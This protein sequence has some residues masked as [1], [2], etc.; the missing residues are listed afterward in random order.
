MRPP[1]EKESRAVST[2]AQPEEEVVEKLYAP[3]EFLR[4]LTPLVNNYLHLKEALVDEKV[5]DAAKGAANLRKQ[6]D[7]VKAS[8]LDEKAA[9]T[10]LKLS[11]II[12]EKAQTLSQMKEIA[13]Q[14]TAFD[15]LSEAFVRLLM[16]FRHVMKEPLSV[17]HC[18]MASEGQGTYWVESGEERR[19]PYFGSKPV[20]GQDMLH[21]G[22]LIDRIPPENAPEG[23]KSASEAVRRGQ[24]LS[25][26]ESGTVQNGPETGP[27]HQER[28]SQ[29][30]EKRGDK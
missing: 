23:E 21:C 25:P 28:D 20:K 30:P 3:E 9:Q 26:S 13:A 6:L 15:P 8:L 22:E 17:L 19:N 14:R 29:S 27:P 2:P 7:E 24:N 1:E 10:W 12:A 4:S 5:E 11:G 16:S 18:P